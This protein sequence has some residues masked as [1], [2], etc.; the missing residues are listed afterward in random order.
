MACYKTTTETER[1]KETGLNKTTLAYILILYSKAT[2]LKKDNAKVRC[3]SKAITSQ[4]RKHLFP[5]QSQCLLG[6][7]LLKY[8][9]RMRSQIS[10]FYG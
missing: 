9:A 4:P 1:Q 3:Q 2:D 6:T 8:G 7:F 10:D 5:Q